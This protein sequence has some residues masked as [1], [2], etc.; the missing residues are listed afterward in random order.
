MRHLEGGVVHFEVMTLWH[1]LEAIQRFAG[2]GYD[3]ARYASEDDEYLLEREPTV[4]H[5]EVLSA[6]PEPDAPGRVRFE[7]P[8]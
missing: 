3:R 7:N 1:S 4:R 2:T 8:P 5:L 6:V